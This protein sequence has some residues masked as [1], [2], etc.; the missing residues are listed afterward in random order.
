MIGKAGIM[1]PEQD[2]FDIGYQRGYEDAILGNGNNCPDDGSK[3]SLGYYFGYS[4]G[5]KSVG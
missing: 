5:M 2:E 4:D 1:T 3:F